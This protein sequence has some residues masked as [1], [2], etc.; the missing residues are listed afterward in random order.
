M[1][2]ARQVRE[3][4]ALLRDPDVQIADMAKRYGVL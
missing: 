3:H 1:L 2:D 4:Q